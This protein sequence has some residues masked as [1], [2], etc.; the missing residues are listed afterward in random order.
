MN[1]IF[2]D[3]NV[4]KEFMKIISTLNNGYNVFLVVSLEDWSIN[5]VESLTKLIQERYGIMS[6]F[7]QTYDDYLNGRESSATEGEGLYNLQQDMFRY[8]YID[9]NNLSKY[10][11]DKEG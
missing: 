9:Y 8:S 4:F 5:L 7:V 3:D 2:G 1:W 10:S 11:T 6:V